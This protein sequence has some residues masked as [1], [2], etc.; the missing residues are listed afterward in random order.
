[1]IMVTL[2]EEV[3]FFARS[4]NYAICKAKLQLLLPLTSSLLVYNSL[5]LNDRTKLKSLSRPIVPTSSFAAHR[6][7]TLCWGQVFTL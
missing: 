3:L 7:A 2:E 6:I 1:M 5:V 4:I